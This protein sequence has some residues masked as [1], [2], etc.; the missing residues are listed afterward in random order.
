MAE[1]KMKR[2]PVT[3]QPDIEE[4]L[5]WNNYSPD[6]FAGGKKGRSDYIGMIVAIVVAVLML[7]A[8]VFMAV[9]TE[10]DKKK[11]RKRQKPQND[12]K[13]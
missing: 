11:R 10:L 8:A 2:C 9:K 3:L 5:D 6:D 1:K 4:M 12:F 13:Y 7:A